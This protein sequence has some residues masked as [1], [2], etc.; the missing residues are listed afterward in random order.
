RQGLSC[1]AHRQVHFLGLRKAV[2]ALPRELQRTAF[3]GDGEEADIRIGGHRL[4]QL[5]AEYLL[6]VIAANEFANN[7]A[8]DHLAIRTGAIAGFHDMRDQRA[9]LYHLPAPGGRWHM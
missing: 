2:V 3:R 1:R 5:S 9:Y 4:M 6:A 7:V 8:R